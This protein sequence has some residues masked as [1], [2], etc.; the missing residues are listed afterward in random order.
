MTTIADILRQIA[1]TGVPVTIDQA[2][3][4]LGRV[5]VLTGPKPDMSRWRKKLFAVLHYTAQPATGYFGIPPG[6]AVELGMQITI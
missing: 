2:S 1:T 5:T 6:R 4:F 3:F